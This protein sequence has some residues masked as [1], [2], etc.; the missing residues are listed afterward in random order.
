MSEVD[1]S[2]AVLRANGLVE[3]VTMSSHTSVATTKA[4]GLSPR[5]G[6]IRPLISTVIRP[7][8]RTRTW[9]GPLTHGTPPGLTPAIAGLA[10]A[11]L[12]P[13]RSARNTEC[14]RD[15]SE[16]PREPSEGPRDPSECP[17]DPSARAGPAVK[18]TIAKAT[19]AEADRTRFDRVVRM[20]YSLSQRF[21][22]R[23]VKQRPLS[24]LLYTS[25]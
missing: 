7:S 21:V 8:S 12:L 23:P 9:L 1:P 19:A 3:S 20:V 17:L 4:M 16:C 14:P 11:G 2:P 24:C 22:G 5:A 25:D 13:I 6:M 15:P 18:V 10:G